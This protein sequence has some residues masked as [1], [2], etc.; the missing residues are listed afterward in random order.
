MQRGIAA[1][2]LLFVCG[3]ATAAGRLRVEDAWIREAPPGATAMAGYA[4]LRNTGDEA[5][6]LLAVQSAAFR[7]ASVHETVLSGGMSRMRELHDLEIAPGEKVSLQPG[8]RHLMLMDPRNPVALGDKIE[9][10]FLLAD[11]AR[12]KTE[13][14]VVADGP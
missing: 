5:L 7:N 13:F 12:V 6:R 1:L 3:T 2:A 9:I 11:G 8:G 10:V 14:E 4:T